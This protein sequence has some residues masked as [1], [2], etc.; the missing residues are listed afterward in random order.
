MAK[1]TIEELSGSLKEYLNGLGLTEAQVQGLIDKFEDEKIGDISQLSTEEKESLVGAINEVNQKANKEVDLSNYQ[2]KTDNSL[3][4]SSK[5]LVGAI[6]ELFQNA[7]NGKELIAS[8]IGEP[9]SSSDTFSAMS[10]DINGLLSQ[11]KTNMMKNGITIESGDKFKSLIDKIAT[12]VEEGSGKGVQIASGITSNNFSEVQIDGTHFTCLN[13]SLNFKP[14]IL[15]VR[16]H[17]NYGFYIENFYPGNFS[18]V[19]VDNGSDEYRNVSNYEID[20]GNN[21]YSIPIGYTIQKD[22]TYYWAVGVGEEDTTLRDSLADILENKGVDVTEEDDM[23]SLIGKVEQKLDESSNYLLKNGGD[24]SIYTINY[25]YASGNA[26]ATHKTNYLQ[27][28][29]SGSNYQSAFAFFTLKEEIDLT[30]KTM[31]MFDL[32]IN[33]T[34]KYTY[35]AYGV[36]KGTLDNNTTFVKGNKQNNKI[37]YESSLYEKR[38]KYII[39]VSD[40]TGVHKIGLRIGT[41]G[42]YSSTLNLYN[43]EIV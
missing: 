37:D 39:D 20:K 13:I 25:D 10:N 26:T 3:Q 15:I 12:M 43:I 19:T 8:A 14:T 38:A 7:N 40:C 4:T 16:N 33:G 28:S 35:F 21:N 27:F 34:T 1:I 24:P 23:A 30:D 17:G 36:Y 29:T 42:V 41:Y 2:Q 9:L 18:I 32:E 31:I 6:N 22:T 11:F 5:N